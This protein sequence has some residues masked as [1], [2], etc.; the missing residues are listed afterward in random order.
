MLVIYNQDFIVR[1]CSTFFYDSPVYLSLNATQTLDQNQCYLGSYY[2]AKTLT[3]KDFYMCLC[4]DAIGCNLSNRIR[5][6]DY[7]IN[8]F[9]LACFFFYILHF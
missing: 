3:D 8:M 4:N 7:R 1:S 2:D 6:L 9:S 5:H